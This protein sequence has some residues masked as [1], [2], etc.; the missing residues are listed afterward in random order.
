M[1]PEIR[2]PVALSDES[3]YGSGRILLATALA[4]SVALIPVLAWISN[5]LLMAYPVAILG[6]VA[7]VWLLRRPE[8]NLTALLAS[9]VV[10]SGFEEG[11]QLTE[12]IWGLYYLAFMAAWLTS[13][14]FLRD[15]RIFDLWEARI[16]ITFLVLAVLS[17]PLTILFGGSVRGVFGELVSL[18]FL[19]LY[20][21]VR[22]FVREQERGRAV[23]LAIIT[24][25]GLFVLVRNLVNFEEI[26]S[27][28]RYAFEIIRGRVITN[29]PLLLIP[30]VIW[31]VH[32]I[33]EHSKRRL[34][35]IA[36]GFTIFL[37]GLLMTQSRGYWLAFLFASGIVF[38]IVG[39]RE[40]MRL[41]LAGTASIGFT[42]L[43]GYLLFGETFILI[44]TGLLDRFLSIGSAATTDISLINRWNET[45]AVWDKVRVNPIVGYGMGVPY[46]YYNI[47]FRP[48]ITLESAFLHNGYLALWYKF[49]I[50]GLGMMLFYWFASI[51]RGIQVFGARDMG[52]ASRLVGTGVSAALASFVVSAVTS[53]P[54]YLNDTMFMFGVLGGLVGGLYQKTAGCESARSTAAH[55]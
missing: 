44:L 33:H 47:T 52:L 42:L 29:E 53:N 26:V 3:V 55:T 13:R 25:I 51:R 54:F 49:G 9:F 16:L 8:L 27:G 11:T 28:A 48:P 12:V 38:L 17:V 40:R 39:K 41:V 18:S 22:E 21:P 43:L 19:S 2:H 14:V 30:A 35:P 15:G 6:L 45:S 50:W 4:T 10:I 31:M 20:F 24:W 46:H 1:Q 36:L 5:E 32:L 34:V 7:G 37:G 23:V